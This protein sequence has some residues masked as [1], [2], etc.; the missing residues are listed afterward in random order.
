MDKQETL[1]W[2]IGEKQRL[3]AENAALKRENDTLKAFASAERQTLGDGRDYSLAAYILRDM[4]VTKKAE[5]DDLCHEMSKGNASK[6]DWD[7][8]KWHWLNAL[9][10][11]E[12]SE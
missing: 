5:L 3:E 7:G 6:G 4:P 9:L 12:E 2:Y 11:A 1:M 8:L 10:T